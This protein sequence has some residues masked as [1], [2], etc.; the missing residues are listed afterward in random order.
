MKIK[1][2]KGLSLNKEAVTKLQES[3]MAHFKGGNL[4][5]EGTCAEASCFK[6]CNKGSC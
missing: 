5:E 2:T 6:S 3:Q 1:L 4:I